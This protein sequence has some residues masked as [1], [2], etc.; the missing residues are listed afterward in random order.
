MRKYLIIY[1]VLFTSAYNCYGRESIKVQGFL[2]A[3]DTNKV[4]KVDAERFVLVKMIVNNEV[5]QSTFIDNKGFFEFYKPCPSENYKIEFYLLGYRIKPTIEITKVQKNKIVLNCQFNLRHFTNPIQKRKD[6]QIPNCI[7][8]QYCGLP[9]Y[10]DFKLK[11][12]SYKYGLSYENLGCFYFDE[13]KVNKEA[14]KKLNKNLGDNWEKV[15]WKEVES[16][17]K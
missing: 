17:L 10:S 4:S 1:F 2:N 8:Y 3:N 6:F 16:K 13:K 7:T 9:V 11:K 5:F 15:F 12:Y 14:I